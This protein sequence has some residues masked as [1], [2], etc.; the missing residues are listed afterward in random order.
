MTGSLRTRLV[1]ILLA[2]I[3]SAWIA[4]SFLAFL[5]VSRVMQ[6]QVDS[7]LEQYAG[8]VSYLTRVFSR[9]LDEG[10]PLSEP[11]LSGQ[12]ETAHLQPMIIDAP[13]GENLDPALNIWL[14]NNLIAV[15]ADSPRFE[16]PLEEGYTFSLVGPSQVRW[17]ILSRYDATTELW[18]QVGIELDDARAAMLRN[19]GRTLLPLLVVLPLTVALLYFGVARGLRPLAALADQ[20]ARRN[21]DL[22]DPVDSSDVPEELQGVV[23]SLNGL[24]RR[25][26]LALEAEQRFTANAAHELITPLAAIKT[27]VQ[28]CQLQLGDTRGTAMLARIAQRVDRA[29]HTVEQLMTLARL[30]P[31]LPAPR[32]P[33]PLRALLAE[34][35]ADTGHLADERALQVDLAEGEEVTVAGNTEA[36]AILL[37]N[38]LVNAFRYASEAS[39]VTIALS[40][41]DCPGLEINN[42]CEPLAGDE[43][44]RI[45]ERFYRVPGSPGQ[46]AGLGLSI[47]ARIAALHGARLVIGP[48]EEGRGFR[49]LILFSPHQA[50]V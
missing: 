10:E 22:L 17:R 14:G 21:P 32:Q 46:G 39:T 41:G 6:E 11:W 37:R 27:E 18:L 26:A 43:F 24:L 1:L 44:R 40:A 25:L 28:L 48:G 34:A 5:F 3:L 15:M 13:A 49:V 16:A 36:L 35:L 7:Q 19:L 8:L 29:S 4:S 2:L 38:V 23:S 42:D 9:Q 45:N 47:A 30:D 31:G 33:V 20:I 12:F 50:A